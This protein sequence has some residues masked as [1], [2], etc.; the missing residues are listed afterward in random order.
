MPWSLEVVAPHDEVEAALDAAEPLV[1]EGETAPAE[2]VAD[3]RE[4][5]RSFLKHV[6]RT[7]SQV[8]VQIGGADTD[9]DDAASDRLAVVVENVPA[10]DAEAQAARE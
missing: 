4:A 3:A 10:D 5:A 2:Q 1:D 6:G 7:Y 8:R 9:H